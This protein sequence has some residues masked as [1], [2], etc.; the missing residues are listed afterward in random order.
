MD[1]DRNMFT[2][3]STEVHRD[4][5]TRLRAAFF[6]VLLCVLCGYS[7]LCPAESLAADPET[8]R[9]V[10]E[11]N[12]TLAA[13]HVDDALKT[14]DAV[15]EHLPDSPEL[16][17]DRGV[18]YYR[19]GNRAKATENFEKALTTRDIALEA[20]AKFNLGN[21]AYA[22]ALE[23]QNDAKAALDKLKT[24]IAYYKD[25]IAANPGDLDAK[26]NMET[27]QL[28]MKDLLDK[29]KKKQ[30]E[31]KKH[32]QSQPSSQPESQPA[33]QPQSQPASQPQQP[34][35]QPASQPQSGQQKKDQQQKQG[36]QQKEGQQKQGQ[37][38]KQDQ[39]KGEQKQAG[40]Q[41]EQKQGEKGDELEAQKDQNQKGD[42][43]D[44]KPA[45][46][47]EVRQLSKQE[48]E[49]LLQLIRDRDRQRRETQIRLKQGTL[50]PVDKD[51]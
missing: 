16:A 4:K 37:Q 11:A 34:Q 12:K 35:S 44:A 17:Y 47:A 5:T 42:Q 36:Q 29:E 30:D 18:A 46:K 10:A 45:S 22:D 41:G 48:A 25:A 32:P 27:A 15:G 40:K 14:Y 1:A 2:T 19:K 50:V 51:W 21:C 20:R 49:K 26:V 39:Q 13:G 31:Q 23:K 9:K 6:S 3:E 33:S 43:K 38:Q 24:A 28:F 7:L 8:G